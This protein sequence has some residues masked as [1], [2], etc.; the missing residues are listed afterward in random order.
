MEIVIF[1][2]E[3]NSGYCRRTE[4]FINEIIEIGAVKLNEDLEIT[5]QFSIFIRPEITRRLNST[6]RELTQL[7][8]E[9]L[10]HGATY[11]YAISKFGKFS[12]DCILMSW[13]TSDLNALQAN[14]KYYSGSDVVPFLHQYADAQAYFQDVTG[15]GGKN[16][17]AL[18]QAAERL[19]IDTDDI[20]LHRAVGDSILTARILKKLYDPVRFAGYVQ[21]V[22]D[23][24]Y[25][26]LNFH[27]TYIVNIENPL[28]DK[29]ELYILCP[30][31]GKVCRQTGEWSV[32]NKGFQSDFECPVC[33]EKYL[34]RVQ[35]RLCYEGLKIIRKAKVRTDPAPEAEEACK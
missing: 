6:V 19:D 8:N 3:W 10:R 13:S 25:R 27:T 29:D 24:F 17:T 23:E 21:R 16:Q 11:N 35:F 31:C 32:R 14:C 12:K 9:D 26:R 22:D 34:G 28:I 7:T 5:G 15:I 1:D 33:G 4:G 20:P 18:Q 2:L 30:G